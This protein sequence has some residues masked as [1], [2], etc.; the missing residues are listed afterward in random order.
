VVKDHGHGLLKLVEKA[1]R[2]KRRDER[3]AGRRQQAPYDEYWVMADVDAH[4]QAEVISALA[5]ASENGIWVA[6]SNPCIELWLLWHIRDW[7]RHLSRYEAQ[8]L[9]KQ[10][11]RCG[12][13]LTAE[14]IAVLLK[15]HEDAAKRARRQAERHQYDGS[16]VHKNP[17]STAWELV[18]SIRQMPRGNSPG[19]H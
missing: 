2:Q 5:T 18:A 8:K 12:K 3:P 4:T 19:L 9:A 1:Q 11:L 6:L 13:A 10:E 17:A 16:W 15:R 14:A 7:E